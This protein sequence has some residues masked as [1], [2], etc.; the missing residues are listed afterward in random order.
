MGTPS[1]TCFQL[2]EESLIPDK[3]SPVTLNNVSLF[4][5][6]GESSETLM[7]CNFLMFVAAEETGS[8]ARIGIYETYKTINMS[9]HIKGHYQ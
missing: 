5:L 3:T 8:L 6:M 4:K 9:G 2:E 1:M 7:L